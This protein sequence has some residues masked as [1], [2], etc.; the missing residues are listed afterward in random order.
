MFYFFKDD[1][2]I[3]NSNL[4]LLFV[5]FQLQIFVIKSL[6][7]IISAQF[8]VVDNWGY[9][10]ITEEDPLITTRRSSSTG[11][12][13]RALN[14]PSSSMVP[15]RKLSNK[16]P[17]KLKYKMSENP[18]SLHQTRAGGGVT[19]LPTSTFWNSTVSSTEN[20]S[21]RADSH[22]A[23][24][25]SVCVC[26]SVCVGVMRPI[27]TINLEKHLDDVNDG[28]LLIYLSFQNKGSRSFFS[29]LFLEGKHNAQMDQ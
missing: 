12:S 16:H 6:D 13:R 17:K 25:L 23:V 29:F 7:H 14:A 10:P 9:S 19:Q 20:T 8:T 24:C 5:V 1:T 18:A 22:P 28:S 11:G 3:S 26:V 15:A 2:N 27:S 21:V 4:L